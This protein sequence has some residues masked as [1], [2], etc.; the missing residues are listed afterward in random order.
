[1]VSNQLAYSRHDFGIKYEYARQVCKFGEASR[2]IKSLYLS[3]VR[4]WNSFLEDNKACAHDFLDSY[5][6][7]IGACQHAQSAASVLNLPPVS[8]SNSEYLVNGVHRLAA[9]MLTGLTVDQIETPSPYKYRKDFFEAYSNPHDGSKFST[10]LIS[11]MSRLFIESIPCNIVFI[12]PRAIA[13]DNGLYAESTLTSSDKFIFRQ[14][15]K[16]PN[17][18]LMVLVAHFYYDQAWIASDQGLDWQAILF[19]TR[20]IL[21]SAGLQYID[22]YIFSS[23]GQDLIEAKQNIR[24]Y[25]KIENSSVHSTDTPLQAEI[26]FQFLSTISNLSELWN[27]NSSPF[28]KVVNQYL[29]RE[30]KNP[31]HS[32]NSDKIL[33]GSSISDIGGCRSANDIDFLFR[34]NNREAPP[35]NSHNKYFYLYPTSINELIDNPCYFF[36]LFGH[37]VL[38]LAPYLYFKGMRSEPKDLEDQHL[39]S[40]PFNVQ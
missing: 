28:S 39:F 3:H 26:A 15:Y 18:L 38:S 34:E 8:V 1:M 20:Q 16:I 25:Y 29:F 2:Y 23:N 32:S 30:I 5:H 35:I 9:T 19:K 12:L 11:E 4:C 36:Y 10:G 40:M 37:K 14:R 31:S 27:S 6:S 24:S 7:L 17:R 22:C 21:N 13:H 33:V